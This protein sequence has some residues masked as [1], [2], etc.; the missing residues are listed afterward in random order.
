M[1]L[2]AG[3]HGL[4]GLGVGRHVERA[5]GH[6]ARQELRHLGFPTVGGNAGGA[7]EG[8]GHRAVGRG[9][10]HQFSLVEKRGD[11]VF[12]VS[13]AT[14]VELEDV[15]FTYSRSVED[16]QFGH[17][18]LNRHPLGSRH[19][20]HLTGEISTDFAGGATV[21]VELGTIVVNSESSGLSRHQNHIIHLHVVAGGGSGGA[22]LST[23]LHA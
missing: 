9:R 1:C 3:S 6:V 11:E 7:G 20:S 4:S 2:V 13:F 16:G 5:E 21:V 12:L 10:L 15:V 17:V 14:A 18:D 22:C 19:E 8:D 23:H